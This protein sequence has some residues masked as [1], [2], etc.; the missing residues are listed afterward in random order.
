MFFG[1]NVTEPKF[2]M[3]GNSLSYVTQYKYLGVIVVAGKHFS[4]SHL[5]PLIKFR[6]AANTVLNAHSKPSEHVL[7]KLL[8]STCVPMLTYACETVSYS[9]KQF[10]SFNVALND[11]IRPIFGYNRWESVHFL[12]LTLGYPSITDIFYRRN[13]QFLKDIPHIGNPTMHFL[14]LAAKE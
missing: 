9:T 8:Y 5:N 4:T 6:S 2:T 7:M 13:E 11:C 14:V 3:Y 10:H 12:R 1:K